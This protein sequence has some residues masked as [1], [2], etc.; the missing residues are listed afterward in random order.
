MYRR[1]LLAV[2][3]VLPWLAAPALAQRRN[4]SPAK[5]PKERVVVQVSDGDPKRWNLAL[6]T[7]KALQGEFGADRIDVAIVAFGAGVNMLKDDSSVANRIET[8]IERKIFLV[9]CAA[10]MKALN[11]SEDSLPRAVYV[12]PSGAA[13]LVRRQRAGWAVLR[14]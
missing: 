11:V 6:D 2:L 13:E 10:S 7:A 14:P 3:C 5:P 8:A 12:V 1:R 4:K 9:A